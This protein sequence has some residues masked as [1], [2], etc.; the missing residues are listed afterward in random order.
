MSRYSGAADYRQAIVD[1]NSA[2]RITPDHA[3]ALCARGRAKLN[4]ND[5]S[6]KADIAKA[7]QLDGSACP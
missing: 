3:E 5:T 4:I 6:G 2:L 7:R 1:Y